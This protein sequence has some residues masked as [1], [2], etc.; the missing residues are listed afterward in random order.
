MHF[1]TYVATEYIMF[2]VRREG[3]RWKD[4][5]YF[6]DDDT[7]DRIWQLYEDIMC[8]KKYGQLPSAKY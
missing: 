8:I 2:K 6:N 7:L 1:R 3:K 4:G 5:N